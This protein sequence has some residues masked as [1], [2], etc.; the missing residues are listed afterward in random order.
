MSNLEEQSQNLENEFLKGLRNQTVIGYI[1]NQIVVKSK[2]LPHV[3]VLTNA[4]DSLKI[5]S[6][7]SKEP[8]DYSWNYK[9]EEYGPD[10]VITY[11]A[12][13]TK[14][15]KK[16]FH[17]IFNEKIEEIAVGDKSKE[18]IA[19]QA[20]QLSSDVANY[21]DRVF[22]KNFASDLNRY[23][24]NAIVK[25]DDGQLQ[26]M[27]VVG[28]L[29]ITNGF[30]MSSPSTLYNKKDELCNVEDPKKLLLLVDY[31]LYGRGKTASIFTNPSPVL[32]ELESTFIL[33]PCSLTNNV[34]A[35]LIDTEALFLWTNFEERHLFVDGYVA[36]R[37]LLD[38]FWRKWIF[39]DHRP[40]FCIVQDDSKTFSTSPIKDLEKDYK[41][42]S[43]S[44]TKKQVKEW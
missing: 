11:R 3:K 29:L 8:K 43:L 38:H 4:G 34:K 37:K 33:I 26:D 36:V 22:F 44:M 17:T 15:D 40:A 10:E 20:K 25:L 12:E 5:V 16:I 28:E 32:R 35:C 42:I 21:Y 7:K 6:L 19:K 1:N 30:Q 23:S 39:V 13:I 2:L 18:T 24:K 31:S 14:E 27:Q 9:S 41:D